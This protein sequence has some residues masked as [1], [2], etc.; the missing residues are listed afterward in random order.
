MARVT[1]GRMREVHP[2]LPELGSHSSR[3]AKIK[4]NIAPSQNEGMAWPSEMM[5][6]AVART[7]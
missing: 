4:T 6:L 2:D 7:T 3:T 1:A 5:A